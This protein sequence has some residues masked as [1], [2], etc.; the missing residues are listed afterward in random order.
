MFEL[1]LDLLPAIIVLVPLGI[2]W[3]VL[4]YRAEKLT[5]SDVDQRIGQGQ[6]VVLKFF[7]NS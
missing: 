1:F 4:R 3:F 6:P 2:L 7:R 5:P